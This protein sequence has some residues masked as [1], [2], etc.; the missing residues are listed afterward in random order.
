MIQLSIYNTLSTSCHSS[1]LPGK[2][3]GQAET[4]V[5][6][7]LH[8][9]PRGLTSEKAGHTVNVILWI[10]YEYMI[11]L[12]QYSP[13]SS[14]PKGMSLKLI[15]FSW[16]CFPIVLLWQIWGGDFHPNWNTMTCMQTSGSSLSWRVN[17]WTLKLSTTSS[18]NYHQRNNLLQTMQHLL[19]Y[20]ILS[21]HLSAAHP[22]ARFS[23][24]DSLLRT[25]MM[26]QIAHLY[27]SQT[28]QIY[29]SP[30]YSLATPGNHIRSKNL[31][32]GQSHYDL[33]C[34]CTCLLDYKDSFFLSY[35]LKKRKVLI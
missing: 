32:Q 9:Q 20:P 11:L 12:Q 15:V 10:Q 14:L 1:M 29:H 33:R 28:V 19:S 35:F 7:G 8:L 13:F 26:P 31:K 34:L 6:R 18:T 17:M 23:P 2:K 5:P 22:Y 25:A 24:V 4:P 27:G 16:N 21:T 30:G 3:N